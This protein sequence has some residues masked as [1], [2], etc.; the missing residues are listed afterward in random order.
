MV[1]I[2]LQRFFGRD[3]FWRFFGRD[4]SWSKSQPE[5]SEFRFFRF[6]LLSFSDQNPRLKN[7]NS[8]FFRLGFRIQK[9]L[10]R[11][12]IYSK[13]FDW[14]EVT[15]T[16]SLQRNPHQKSQKSNWVTLDQKTLKRNF[17]QNLWRES[18]YPKIFEEK[19]L[20]KNAEKSVHKPSEETFLPRNWK[21]ESL[22]KN[23]WRHF[24][25]IFLKTISL[26]K[27]VWREIYSKQ[28]STETSTKKVMDETFLPQSLWRKISTQQF[29]Q[30]TPTR[31]ENNYKKMSEKKS[32]PRKSFKKYFDQR[33]SEKILPRKLWRDIRCKKLKRNLH[34]KAAQESFPHKRNRKARTNLILIFK[35]FKSFLYLKCWKIFNVYKNW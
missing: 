35:Y 28:I 21:E 30:E 10:W 6:W 9:N 5:K 24:T 14:R 3:F 32:L 29:L 11:E 15:T 25:K 34:Q 7:L 22:P 4:F 33:L 20:P 12:S 19:S 18:I 13:I 17:I 27:I 16:K 26:L 31:E 23:L 1:R 8:D 2:S